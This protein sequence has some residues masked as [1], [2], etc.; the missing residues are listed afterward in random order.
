M[1]QIKL[2]YLTAIRVHGKDAESYLQAQLSADLKQIPNHEAG[3]AAYCRPNGNVLAIL[4]VARCADDF[5]LITSVSLGNDFISEISRFILRADVRFELLDHPVVACPAGDASPGCYPV[6]STGL[7]YGIAEKPDSA[8]PNDIEQW[9]L[10]EMRAGLVW[11]KRETT[12]S[13]IPQMLGLEKLGGLSFRKGC[14]PG[15]EVIARVRY[16]GKLKQRPVVVE[17]RL[18]LTIA[19]GGGIEVIGKDFSGSAVVLDSVST[20]TGSALFLVARIPEQAQV[21]AIEVGSKRIELVKPA[22]A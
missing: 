13:F 1:S 2:D 21:N 9:R 5:L 8:S 14:Y 3:F 19:P 16:L 4:L 10:T 6:Q 22:Q 17:T 20:G 12:G 11:L 18:P 7:A 15:Q